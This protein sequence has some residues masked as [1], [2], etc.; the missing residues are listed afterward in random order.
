MKPLFSKLMPVA[1]TNAAKSFL[2]G[3]SGQGSKQPHGSKG[4]G[5]NSHHSHQKSHYHGYSEDREALTMSQSSTYEMHMHA[6]SLQLPK[7]LALGPKYATNI[8][9][10]AR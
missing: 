1:L 8:G 5:S 3:G 6:G 4:Y 7:P 9:T 2:S 10:E